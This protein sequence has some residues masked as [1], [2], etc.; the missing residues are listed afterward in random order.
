VQRQ[1]LPIMYSRTSSGVGEGV[2]AS[3]AVAATTWPGVQMPHWKPPH[4]R[5]A[6]CTRDSS[7]SGPASPSTVVISRSATMPTGTRQADISRPSTRMLQAP[8]T[9]TPHPSLV[10]VRPR[11]SRRTSSTGRAG[12]VRTDRVRPLTVT[13]IGS[14]VPLVGPLTSSAPPGTRRDD[15]ATRTRRRDPSALRLC[16]GSHQ[17]IDALPAAA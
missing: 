3:S 1:R 11:S 14:S 4:S 10:P 2:S 7:P 8:H 17:P 15:V 6:R 12:G 5:K 9:P 16:F 13:V